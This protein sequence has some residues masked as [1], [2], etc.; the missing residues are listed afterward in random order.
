[1]YETQIM[2][3]SDNDNALKVWTEWPK[4]CDQIFSLPD[5][6]TFL[7]NVILSKGIPSWNKKKYIKLTSDVIQILSL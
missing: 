1:M 6:K 4:F 2:I 3:A 5:R 7:T